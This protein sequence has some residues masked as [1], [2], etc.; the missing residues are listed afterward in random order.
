MAKFR[1]TV[2]RVIDAETPLQAATKF[3]ADVLDLQKRAESRV[4]DENGTVAEIELTNYSFE[5]R[6]P[7]E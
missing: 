1:V 5:I 4:E 3:R 2:S 7:Q 6:E